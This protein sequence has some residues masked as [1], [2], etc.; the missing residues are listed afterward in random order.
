MLP[1]LTRGPYGDRAL[2]RS[3]SARPRA[4]PAPGRVAPVRSRSGG[5]GR[6]RRVPP[7]TEQRGA[8]HRTAPPRHITLTAEAELP[9]RGGCP[10][11]HTAGSRPR[12]ELGSASIG[13]RQPRTPARAGAPVA[14]GVSWCWL[15]TTIYRSTSALLLPAP[16]PNYAE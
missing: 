14:V 2:V 4:Q 10:A 15:V 6:L 5:R 3:P 12:D 16:Q 9:P 7:V 1:P 13:G 11:R 8:P